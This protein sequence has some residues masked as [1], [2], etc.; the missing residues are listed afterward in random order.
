VTL[1]GTWRR[2]SVEQRRWIIVS[3]IIVTAVS[4]AL[5]NGALAWLLSIGQ[6]DV[7]LWTAPGHSSTLS[8]TLGTLFLLPFFTTLVVSFTVHRAQ[9]AGTLGPLDPSVLSPDLRR[10]IPTSLARRALV[11]GAAIL[12]LLAPLAV[13]IHFAVDFGGVSRGTFALYKVVLGVTLGA[14]VTPLIAVVAMADAVVPV[15]A[16]GEGATSRPDLAEEASP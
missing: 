5:I 11:F 9:E 6:R 4:N 8:D 12:V 3:A 7:P 2:L 1:V 14:L 10:R 15:N 13:L 16:V